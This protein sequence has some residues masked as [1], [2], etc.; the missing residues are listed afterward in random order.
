[1]AG[2][3]GSFSAEF[4][5][6]WTPTPEEQFLAQYHPREA[7]RVGEVFVMTSQVAEWPG[8]RGPERDGRLTGV[9]VGTDWAERPPR[10]VWRHRVGPGWGSF[11]VAGR[12]LYTQEQR[13]EAETV[14]CYD[15][16]TGDEVWIH[17]DKDRFEENVSGAGPRATPTFHEGKVYALSARGRL[18]CLDASTGRV[19]WTRDAREDAGAAVPVWGF[20]SSPL[21]FQGV[22]TVF[23]GARDKSVSAYDAANGGEPLW[24][25]G[26]GNHGYS[27]PQL[28]AP[29][30]CRANPHHQQ[31]GTDGPAPHQGRRALALRLADRTAPP[32]AASSRR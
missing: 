11:A 21:V 17:E 8:F 3:D 23:T 27:S 25:A 13:D 20:A 16:D 12:R 19:V 7:E 5:W 28:G 30:Q 22:V 9:R 31:R 24:Q 15:A 6:R 10:Q 29:R 4:H 14:V 26:E 1:M 32:R 18:N 2:V